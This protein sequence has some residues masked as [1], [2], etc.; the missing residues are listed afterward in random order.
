MPVAVSRGECQGIREL[1]Y[2]R[3]APGRG[4]VTVWFHF[5]ETSICAQPQDAMCKYSFTHQI[6]IK[7]ILCPRKHGIYR[8]SK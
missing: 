2:V 3:A 7:C 6:C 5:L 8:F 4:E 1:T